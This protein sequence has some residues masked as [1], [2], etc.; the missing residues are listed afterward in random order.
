M[1]SAVSV[2]KPTSM[3]HPASPGSTADGNRTGN[4]PIAAANLLDR[5]FSAEKPNQRWV[6]DATE[7]AIAASS[8]LCLAALLD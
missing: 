5:Q 3:C 4:V 8:T 7:F 1:K 2:A 6:G